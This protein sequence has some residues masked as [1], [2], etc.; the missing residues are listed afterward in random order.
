[1]RSWLTRFFNN[2]WY[3]NSWQCVLFLPFSWMFSQL[4]KIRKF[5]YKHAWKKS[6]SFPVPVIVV[7]N[8]SVGGSG[9]TPLVIW[10][11]ELLKTSGYKPAI[12]SRGY[13]GKAASWPQQ[14]RVDSDPIIV[15]DEAVQL[16]RRCQCPIAVGPDRC[17]SIEALL[18]HTDCNI[19]V[20]DDG[21]QHYAM[22]RD[23]EIAVVDGIRRYGNQRLLPAGPLREPVSRLNN[24][25]FIVS[26]GI[27]GRS[28]YAMLVKGLVARNLV[29]DKVQGLERF[30][31]ET[32]HAVCG[33]GNPERFFT[34]LRK[35]GIDIIEHAYSDHHPFNKNDVVFDDDLPVLMT[36]KDAVKCQRFQC[37]QHWFIPV[38]ADLNKHFAP[39]LLALLEKRKNH[40]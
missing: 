2:V 13:K 30:N 31:G 39:R 35:F 8:I 32:V 16:A 11:V 40:G 5:A 9:K 34:G 18:Q 19:I 22:Q 33:I 25:D 36:E 27:A 38:Q 4:V 12:I 7:G 21:L 10:I 14:V 29:S 3:G 15:G 20:S 26:N 28:E 1:M 6:E 17:A 24:V 23:I 37:S